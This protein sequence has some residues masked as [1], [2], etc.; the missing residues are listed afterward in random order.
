MKKLNNSKMEN[1]NGGVKCIY[2]FMAEVAIISNP[3]SF[4]IDTLWGGN[5]TAVIECWNNSHRE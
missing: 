5:G 2:H 3:V 1:I 4:L